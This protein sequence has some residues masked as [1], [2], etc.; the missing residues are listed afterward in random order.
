MHLFP[1]LWCDSPLSLSLSPSLSLSLFL[2]LVSASLSYLEEPQLTAPQQSEAG[3]NILSGFMAI[4][5]RADVLSK[6]L[7]IKVLDR[8]K[9]NLLQ[10]PIYCSSISSISLSEYWPL[11]RG[12]SCPR[13]TSHSP[14]PSSSPGGRTSDPRHSE[15][16][17][18][19]PRVAFTWGWANT[20]VTQISYASQVLL[21]L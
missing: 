2:S 14:T 5:I 20:F 1:W 17:P 8:N 13:Y 12:G 15:S 6:N 9:K 3:V 21:S 18:V 19:T 4:W 7:T 11:V 10:G 16:T